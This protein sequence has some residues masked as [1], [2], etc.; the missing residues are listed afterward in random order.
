MSNPTTVF[1]PAQNLAGFL[2]E[3]DQ[4]GGTVQQL[5]Q[6]K[7]NKSPGDGTASPGFP[8]SESRSRA[9]AQWGDLVDDALLSCVRDRGIITV[10]RDSRGAPDVT[11]S[12]ASG[13]GTGDFTVAANRTYATLKWLRIVSNG[14]SSGGQIDLYVDAART[15]LAFSDTWAGTSYV[16]RSPVTLIGDAGQALESS[17][18]YARLTNNGGSASTYNL[19]TVLEG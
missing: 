18:I 15:L 6:Q 11:A 8:A 7:V 14:A 1:D 17:L 10:C 12:I 4:Y 5:I 19:E 13:G 9:V 3:A 2:A 16:A